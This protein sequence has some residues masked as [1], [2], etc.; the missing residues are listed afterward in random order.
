MR[1][2]VA[3]NFRGARAIIAQSACAGRETL[4]TTLTRLGLKVSFHDD[5][6]MA[7]ASPCDVMFSDADEGLIVAASDTPQIAL[8]GLEAPS[9]LLRVVRQRCV[10]YLI[11]P[12]R[13]TG[14]FTALFIA[15][16]EHACRRREGAER[17]ALSQRLSGRRS[18]IKAVL[19]LMRD[20]GV[21]DDEA[22]RLLR[23]E[24]MRRRVSVEAW[25]AA[26]VAAQDTSAQ[27]PQA[28]GQSG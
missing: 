12:V 24:A 27:N 3:P 14:V 11:K 21:D 22:F 10:S 20:N 18:V 6:A 15:F 8:I 5:P 9:R 7:D 28:A 1:G 23:V 4:A 25:A 17:A 2:P 16:N 19:L 26:L 13:P